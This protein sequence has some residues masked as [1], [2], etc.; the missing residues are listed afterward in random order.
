MST[1]T[2]WKSQIMSA[3]ADPDSDK[4]QALA[5]RLEAS[6]RAMDSLQN[7]GYRMDGR[8]ID[9]IIAKDV[10]NYVGGH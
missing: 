8:Q 4:M 10:P 5:A 6:Y 1:G 9:T 2:F 7:K 3:A